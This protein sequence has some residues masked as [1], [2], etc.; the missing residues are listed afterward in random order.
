MYLKALAGLFLVTSL[1]FAEGAI[2]TV[3]HCDYDDD[4]RFSVF[5][6]TLLHQIEYYEEELIENEISV[7]INGACTRYINQQTKDEKFLAM[8][9]SRIE[10][11]GVNVYACQSGMKASGV[12]KSDIKG[13]QVVPNGGA[14][15]AELQHEGFAYIKVW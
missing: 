6:A 12:K 10:N 4:E 2:K 14:K 7:V 3:Y 11:Y 9:D 13:V 8:L 1:S 15:L 5:M